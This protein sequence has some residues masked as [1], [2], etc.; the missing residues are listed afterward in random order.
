MKED[1]EITVDPKPMRTKDRNKAI[2]QILWGRNN[3]KFSMKRFGLA[4][5]KKSLKREKE[6]K[7]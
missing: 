5:M 7:K 2:G 4:M 3:G 6:D 1:K